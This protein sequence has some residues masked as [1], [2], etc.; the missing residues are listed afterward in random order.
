MATEE[1]I[2]R[3]IID[4]QTKAFKVG[5]N[6]ISDSLDKVTEAAK[7]AAKETE[8]EGNE[9]LP[10]K[11]LPRKGTKRAKADA[12]ALGQGIEFLKL[13]L[14]NLHEVAK[15]WA[16]EWKN[17]YLG[18][19]TFRK[20]TG[21][22]RAEIKE[23]R[24]DV[25]RASS[26]FGVAME[27]TAQI[28]RSVARGSTKAR[29]SI[30][31]LA[32][33]MANLGSTTGQTQEQ[34]ADLTFLF[35]RQMDMTNEAAEKTAFSIARTGRFANVDAGA[36]TDTLVR[37]KQ[38]LLAI[39]RDSGLTAEES[40]KRLTALTTAMFR[41]GAEAGDVD[42][43]M[44]QLSDTSSKFFGEMVAG[45]FD[46]DKIVGLMADLE[47]V[48]KGVPGSTKKLADKFGIQNSTV[49]ALSKSTGH[50]RESLIAFDDAMQMSTKTMREEMEVQMD[51][52]TRLDRSWEKLKTGVIGRVEAMIGPLEE[53]S[54]AVGIAVDNMVEGFLQIDAFT[55]AK[56]VVDVLSGKTRDVERLRELTAI[57]RLENEARMLSATGKVSISQGMDM[58]RRAQGMRTRGSFPVGVLGSMTQEQLKTDLTARRDKVEADRKADKMQT[59][60]DR[61]ATALENIEHKT[62]NQRAAGG[63]ETKPFG[64]QASVGEVRAGIH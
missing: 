49:I 33:R 57:R 53:W 63:V 11:I 24:I 1:Q 60:M 23:F 13:R 19:E 25:I 52:L 21:M 35:S 15:D 18:M 36:L 59:T 44:S 6:A 55:A 43:V 42:A 51:L 29:S 14:G 16:E 46:L 45:G 5:I 64:P 22:T 17:F 3:F 31:D 27:K 41:G 56:D 39:S 10:G 37:H 50:Y 48:T 30:A 26:E 7:D 12:K 62:D 2:L 9:G 4:I 20:Q 28:A 32:A 40:V 61:A 47:A 54:R 58:F 38:L 34:I 8:S